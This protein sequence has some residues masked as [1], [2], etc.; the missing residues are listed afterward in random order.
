M[1]TGF[2]MKML[3]IFLL[4]NILVLFIGWNGW[5]WLA[6]LFQFD[7]AGYYTA[8][9]LIFSYSYLLGRV[10]PRLAIFRIIGSYWMAIVQYAILILPF[11]DIS[12]GILYYLS[13]PIETL[14]FWT[15][16][17]VLLLLFSIFAYGTFN[18][19]SPIVRK[20]KITIPK[21]A[22]SYRQLRIA[23]ASDMHFGILS[24]KSHLK[25]LVSK[26]NAI[27]PDLVLFP[28]DIIDDEPGPFHSKKYGGSD[29][30]NKSSFGDIRNSG[31]S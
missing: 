31:E 5:V 4:Y 8:T 29:E 12:V 7:H 28:G 13:F 18:A 22:G 23:M 14:V 19:Y 27:K 11:A 16:I 26:V 6:T 24:G 25:R 3:W 30:A 10:G 21:Q 20:Y 2:M 15:G 1:K 17:I 9:L